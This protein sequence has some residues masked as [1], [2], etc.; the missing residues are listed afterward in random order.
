MEKNTWT[1]ETINLWMNIMKILFCHRVT[2]VLKEHY[3]ASL[4]E[5][6]ELV[7]PEDLS[8]STLVKYAA[9]ID[10][11]VGYKFTKEFLDQ[12]G[13]LRHIQVPW[14]GVETLDFDL[15]KQYP[16][17]TI[18]NSHSNSLAIAEHAVALFLSAA[19]KIVY[20]DSSMRKGDWSTRYNDVT[21]QWLTG[22]I[23]G[24]IGYG[25]IGRKVARMMKRGFDM[26][27]YAIK[28]NLPTDQNEE[29]DF[30][31]D[32]DSLDYVLENSDYLLLALPLTPETKGLIG[33]KEL[34]LLKRNIVL[35]NIGRG[36]VIDEETLYEFMKKSDQAAVG[37]D[38]WYNYPKDRKKPQI[39][40]HFP[41]EE[42]FFLVMS[43]H[44]AFKVESREIPF[45]EDIIRN[46]VAI[47]NR[48]V[49]ENQVQLEE[50][51]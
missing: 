1:N 40:Q 2:P 32:L 43:P 13:K 12:A 28:R 24:V 46:L 21:S 19:K 3:R 49:P 42:L 48:E 44:S 50:E 25:A 7:F 29:V 10:I 27:I 20:R 37:L 39:N 33:E 23:L 6:I 35:V 34:A 31:G 30:L 5:Q 45:A 8:E 41:F 17:I 36:D 9:D 16:H 15:M 11:A 47:Y 14:T 38:V 22:R 26:Q 4:P 18:S 51:Y